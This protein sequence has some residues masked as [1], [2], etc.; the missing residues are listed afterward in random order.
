MGLFSKKPTANEKK[1]INAILSRMTTCCKRLE[2]TDSIDKYFTE[3]DKYLSDYE[4][5][6]YFARKGIKFTASPDRMHSLICREVPRLEK[7]IINRG[8]DRML[9]DAAKLSTEKGKRTKAEKF[10]NELE[11]YYPKMQAT[12]VELV[13]ELKSKTAFLAT[14]D[15]KPKAAVSGSHRFCK[16]CGAAIDEGDLFCG[17]CGTKVEM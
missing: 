7:D 13:K 16:Q 5:L 4:R 17:A 11:F 15:S 12:S 10:F 9:R 3:W 14:A 6:S 2:A 8:Y 1:E